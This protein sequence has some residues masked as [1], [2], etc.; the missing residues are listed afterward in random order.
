MRQVLHV[1]C[2]R[3]NDRR[4]GELEVTGVIAHEIDPPVGV[5]PIVWRLLINHTMTD[6][7]K[8]AYLLKKQR[9]PNDPLTPNTMI[10][11]VATLGGFLGRKGEGEPGMKTLWLGFQRVHDF[12]GGVSFVQALEPG[13]RSYV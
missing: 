4:G 7:E 11:L 2:L 5:K 9:P 10:R 13:E 12:V 6:A 3:L 1:K 8:A